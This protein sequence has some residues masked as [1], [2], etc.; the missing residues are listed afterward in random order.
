MKLR[1]E[2]PAPRSCR[3]VDLGIAD[4]VLA[5]GRTVVNV[6][7]DTTVLIIRTWRRLFA[8]ASRCPHLGRSLDDA[9][10]RMNLLTCRGHGYEFNLQ[11]GACVRP[12]QGGNDGLRT[13]VAYIRDGRLFLELPTACGPTR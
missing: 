9:R 5:D 12:R 4:D 3:T 13:Y 1:R 10:V 8:V 7:D 11:S 6:D 2:T